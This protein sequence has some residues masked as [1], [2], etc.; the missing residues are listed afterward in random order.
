MR[1]PGR[2]TYLVLERMSG[3]LEDV[4]VEHQ[5]E[6]KPLSNHLIQHIVRGVARALQHLHQHNIV[7]NDVSPENIMFTEISTASEI[8]NDS[9]ALTHTSLSPT[10]A[11]TATAVAAAAS[12]PLGAELILTPV[13]SQNAPAQPPPPSPM[14]LTCRAFEATQLEEAEEEEEEEEQQQQP[15]ESEMQ[16]QLLQTTVKL[17]DLG[18]AMPAGEVVG[19]KWIHPRLRAPELAWVSS[20]QHATL[21]RT[22]E[23]PVDLW[24]LGIVLAEMLLGRRPFDYGRELNLTQEH[25]KFD[26]HRLLTRDLQTVRHLYPAA[27]ALVHELL[28]WNAADR[29]TCGQLLQHSFLQ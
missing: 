2:I 19:M 9:A 15:P 27:V 11:S 8:L 10:T 25:I 1:T 21:A 26:L 7:M 20:Q 24:A 13:R 18:N 23:P 12:L 3:A 5:R 14:T 4:I 29:L 16:R 17:I 6:R 28:V 22:Y